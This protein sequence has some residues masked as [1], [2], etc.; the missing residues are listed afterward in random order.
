[1]RPDFSAGSP[2]GAE[3]VRRRGVSTEESLCGTNGSRAFVQEL[4]KEVDEDG[5]GILD[6]PE[7]VALIAR[8]KRGDGALKA[9]AKV[10]DVLQSSPVNVVEQQAKERDITI[11]YKHIQVY[12]SSGSGLQTPWVSFEPL[13]P[14]VCRPARMD[15]PASAMWCTSASWRGT[16]MS[17][18]RARCAV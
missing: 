15:T 1:M 12:T 14:C 17:S 16:G 6:F 13:V 10:F 9:F 7:F 11:A 4:L 5:S 3:V 2:V 18:S 8:I